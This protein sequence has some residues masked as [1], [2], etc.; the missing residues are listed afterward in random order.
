MAR[1]RAGIFL[2]M[3]ALG[4]IFLLMRSHESRK[5]SSHPSK[6]HQGAYNRRFGHFCR[7]LC[8]T[9]WFWQRV[10]PIWRRP[11]KRPSD[12]AREHHL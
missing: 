2:G 10:V 7:A 12:P 6:L 5:K 9:I 11:L 1:S 3:I 4:G 8:C